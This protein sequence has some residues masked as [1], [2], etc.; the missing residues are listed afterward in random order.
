M[1]ISMKWPQTSRVSC[2]TIRPSKV[3]AVANIKYILDFIL[4]SRETISPK[5]TWSRYWFEAT[6]S[7]FLDTRFTGYIYIRILTRYC[8][9][10]SRFC[11]NRFFLLVK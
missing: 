8:F 11:G 3:K 5:L 4:F 10:A 7:C 1:K 9:F 2:K 6:P